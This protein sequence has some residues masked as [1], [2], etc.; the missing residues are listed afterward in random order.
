MVD[1][2]DRFSAEK[3]IQCVVDGGSNV[4]GGL[5]SATGMNEGIVVD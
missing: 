1:L 4:E 3:G 2:C 5:M